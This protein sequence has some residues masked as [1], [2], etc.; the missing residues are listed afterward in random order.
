LGV[1]NERVP[2]EGQDPVTF[3]SDCREGRCGTWG[4]VI[5][6]I[7]HGPEKSTTVC[8]LHMRHFNDGDE[9][10][11]EP[12]RAKAFPPLKD[13]IVDRQAFDCII[14]RGGFITAGT[15]GAPEANGI[16]VAKE[17]ADDAMDSAACIGCGAC[18]AAC[19]NA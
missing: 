10:T 14:Q 2:T 12:W 8:Q 4:F 19:P 16:A 3:D 7:A 1:V 13:L 9:L 6:G 5:N 11:L 15:G 17:A 18:V